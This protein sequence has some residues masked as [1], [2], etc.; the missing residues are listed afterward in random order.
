VAKWEGELDTARLASVLNRRPDPRDA[1]E[2]A[3]AADAQDP[4]TT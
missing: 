4:A 3:G 1:E 2:I